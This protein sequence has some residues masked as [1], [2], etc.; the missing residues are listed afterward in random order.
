[1]EASRLYAQRAQNSAARMERMTREMRIIAEKTKK[2]TVSMKIITWVTLFFLPGTFISV[3]LPLRFQDL[4]LR[5][6]T[7]MSTPIV[8][9]NKNKPDFSGHNIG[10]GALKLYLA[11]S[12][13]L[14][15]ITLLAWWAVSV[16]ENY[17]DK[18]Q[19]EKMKTDRE[20]LE[21]YN[22]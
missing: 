20:K 19:R 7:L 8:R 12:L 14:V 10:Y 11:I 21:Q 22:G 5:L 15:L 9:F 16:R 6:Q 18:T 1:M 17:K 4:D 13:P 3:S 2:D